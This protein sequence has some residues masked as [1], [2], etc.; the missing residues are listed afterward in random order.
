VLAVVPGWRRCLHHLAGAENSS[1][2][3]ASRYWKLSCVRTTVGR[4]SAGAVVVFQPEASRVLNSDHSETCMRPRTP[5]QSRLCGYR[6]T[7]GYGKLVEKV[8]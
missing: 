2:D 1:S 6:R 7:I 3:D 8:H 4:V 5:C